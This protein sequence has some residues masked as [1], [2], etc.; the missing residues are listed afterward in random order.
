MRNALI[1]LLLFT[2][3]IFAQFGV[4]GQKIRSDQIQWIYGPT[5]GRPSS[6]VTGFF[7]FNTDSSFYQYYN[8]S[9]WVDMTDLTNFTGTIGDTATVLRN[10]LGDTI[11]IY[12]TNFANDSLTAS[13]GVEKIGG[14]NFS[15]KIVKDTTALKAYKPDSAGTVVYLKQSGI[16][17]DFVYKSSGSALRGIRYAAAGG[18]VWERVEWKKRY[19]DPTWFGASVNASAATNAEAFTAAFRTA[20]ASGFDTATVVI[21]SG[22]YNTNMIQMPANLSS[23]RYGLHILG[24]SKT[25]LY[26]ED[27]LIVNNDKFNQRMKI[28]N[29]TF[30]SDGKAGGTTAFRSKGATANTIWF[31]RCF[32]DSLGLGVYLYDATLTYGDATVFRECQVALRM[33]YQADAQNWNGCGF[34]DNDT[35]VYLTNTSNDGS[36]FSGCSFNYNKVVFYEKHTSQITVDGGYGEGNEQWMLSDPTSGTISIHNWLNFVGFS[37]SQLSDNP[38]GFVYTGAVIF[39]MKGCVFTGVCDTTFFIFNHSS[40]RLDMSGNY[41]SIQNGDNPDL[42]WKNEGWPYDQISN[43]NLQLGTKTQWASNLNTHSNNPRDPILLIDAWNLSTKYFLSI[44]AHAVSDTTRTLQAWLRGGPEFGLRS[45]GKMI[46]GNDTIATGAILEVDGNGGFLPP[47]LTQTVINNLTA[48]PEGMM[49]YNESIDRYQLRNSTQWLDIFTGATGENTF[50]STDQTDTVT[51]SGMTTSGIVLVQQVGTGYNVN[52]ILR[53][54]RRSGDFVVHRNAA[55][56]SGLG[57]TWI[58]IKEKP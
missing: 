21:P 52:D 18:G 36:V 45:G 39:N 13:N 16:K 31:E 5:S 55:G 2:L 38:F 53:V 11:A 3:S 27:S 6:P 28:E 17:G 20:W 44:F 58:W 54:E 34:F 48:T 25:V 56:T 51:V 47:R 14:R 41:I 12:L 15:Q 23:R 35:A 26:S 50:N 1:F 37:S 10:E 42:F 49:L 7:Y 29:I 19:V 33:E 43:K 24:G 46:V 30:K 8:G 22:R 4:P 57:Y 32:F 9:S 40:S